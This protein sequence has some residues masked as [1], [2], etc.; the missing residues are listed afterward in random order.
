[1]ESAK[2]ALVLVG[3]RILGALAG[4]KEE[5]PPPS[6]R[7]PTSDP[8]AV[9]SAVEFDAAALE[10]AD[11]PAPAG[12]LKADLDGFVNLSSCIAARASLDPLVGDALR[13]IA[14]DTF[15]R[16]ACRML[17]AAKDKKPDT[18][19]SIDSSALRMKCEA[20]VAILMQA[21][22]GCPL[23][24]PSI[25]SRGRDPS[26]VALAAKDPRLCVAEPRAS[27]RATCEAMATRDPKKCQPLLPAERAGCERETA[28]WQKVLAPPLDGLPQ[29]KAASGTLVVVGESGTADPPRKEL[30]FSSELARGLVVV[31][32]GERA[33][34]DLGSIFEREAVRIAAPPNA[35]LRLA[36]TLIVAP[37]GPSGLA[38]AASPGKAVA[39]VSVEKLTLVLPGELPIVAPPA[40]CDCEVTT[41]HLD[42]N[43]G[44]DATFAIKGTLRG[45]GKTYRMSVEATSFV[46]DVVAESPASRALPPMLHT[47]PGLGRPS[48]PSA[49]APAGSRPASGPPTGSDARS[50]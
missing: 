33:R 23:L 13:G 6:R 46:R 4:C 21:P 18:C 15:L 2:V 43:R 50:P 31:T 45:A 47:P 22:E 44:G 9:V 26:C 19:K 38:G 24:S 17:E 36:A 8:S 49:A 16:D 39:K 5:R 34:V 7:P 37:P 35:H 42:R 40:T 41:S 27:S 28:R 20:W 14:Y 48:A 32:A 10:S 29:L 3:L 25:P 11:P 30:E 1:M 12:D